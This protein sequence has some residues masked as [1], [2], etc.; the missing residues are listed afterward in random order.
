MHA[1]RLRRRDRLQAIRRR[2]ICGLG[3][4]GQVFVAQLPSGTLFRLFFGKGS[5]SFK[6]KPKK[7]APFFPWPLG[8]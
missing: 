7:E 6:L 4:T 2:E 1:A 5:D 3:L 8:T